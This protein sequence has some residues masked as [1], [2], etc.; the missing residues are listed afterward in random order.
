MKNK[1]QQCLMMALE[2]PFE[3]KDLHLSKL[4][5]LDK[6]LSQKI[7][8]ETDDI[9]NEQHYNNVIKKYLAE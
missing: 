4:F 7:F 1:I 8:K 9:Q 6:E 5:S 2:S 3:L